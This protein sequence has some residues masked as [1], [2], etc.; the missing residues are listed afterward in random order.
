[1]G[2]QQKFIDTV[3][4]YYHDF[5]RELPWRKTHDP[6]KIMV[7]EFMLQQTQV[8][9]VTEKYQSFL[10]AFADV[11]HLAAA[12]PGDV[13]AE[14]SGLGYNRRA[15]YLHRAAQAIAG[16]YDGQVPNSTEELVKLPGIGVNTAA[17]IRVY[18]FNQP[19]VFIE[20]NIRRVYIHHFF[21]DREGV[22]DSEILPLVEQTID[23]DSP[24]EWYWALMDY[25]NHLAKT[26]PN[27]NRR[28]KHYVRQ[29]K[30]EGSVRQLRGEILRQLQRRSLSPQQLRRAIKHERIDELDSLV[31]QLEKEG[32]LV[33]ESGKLRLS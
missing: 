4:N 29:S 25:G 20:T 26:L 2:E 13:I 10:K 6:Y 17:A 15:L 23:P 21:Q 24:R 18:A 28:S 7:S 27:P 5:G 11:R 19:C 9:R 3:W 33:S 31:A 22:A 30:F 16:Q 8:S 32:F 1:M 12:Q 14:W